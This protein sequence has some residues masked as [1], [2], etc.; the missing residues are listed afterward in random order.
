MNKF[1]IKNP[2]ISEKATRQSAMG[3][4]VFLVDKSLNK[5]EAKKLI[6][7]IYKVDAIDVK[8]MNVRPKTRRSYRFIGEKPGYKKIIATLKKG[9]KLDI[10]PK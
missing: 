3:R 10:F 6:K 9:Q 8:S 1:L 7:E 5:P 2:I 4:Y